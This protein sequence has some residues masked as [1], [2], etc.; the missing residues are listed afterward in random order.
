M[1]IHL[2][3]RRFQTVGEITVVTNPNIDISHVPYSLQQESLNSVDMLLY[4]TT[5]VDLQLEGHVLN[6]KNQLWIVKKFM[7][8][9]VNTKLYEYLLLPVLDNLT[10]RVLDIVTN[11]MGVTQEGT[12]IDTVVNCF[13]DDRSRAVRS[14]QPLDVIQ[15]TF[16]VAVQEMPVDEVYE[17]YYRDRKYKIA[18]M[19]RLVGVVKLRLIE[20]I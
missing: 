13:I 12:S 1:D 10:L 15:Q 11:A 20:D 16:F 18:S 9:V 2:V 3:R 17:V 19:E 6:I 8:E 4:V 5:D 7:L 14:D